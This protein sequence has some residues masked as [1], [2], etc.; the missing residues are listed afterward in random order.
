[1]E[2]AIII[3]Y[4]EIHLKGKNRSFFEKLLRENI[5]KSLNGIN[6]NFKILHSRY[7]IEDFDENDYYVIIDKLQ[8]VA[9]IHT[10]SSALVVNNDLE[11]IFSACKILCENK[12][13][14]FKVDTNGS[15]S[16]DS[17][18]SYK[19]EFMSNSNSNIEL[20]DEIPDTFTISTDRILMK[21]KILPSRI[22]RATPFILRIAV[23]LTWK[24]SH[25]ITI[26]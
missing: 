14:T 4:C 1:M 7:L 3:R 25:W 12:V 15:S 18:Y 10:L 17:S 8:K 26:F 6:Y 22:R 19:V 24:T 9:G 20:I 21:L 2:K 13:G 5:K 23:I 16:N 11:E